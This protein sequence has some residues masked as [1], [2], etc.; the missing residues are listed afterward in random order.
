MAY[1]IP[2]DR[3]VIT[4]AQTGAITNKSL[5]PK[6]PEQPAEIAESAL[7][8]F[9]QG[10]AIVHIH[11]RDP[12]GQNTSELAI[13][14]EIHQRIRSQCE[15]DHPGQHRRRPQPDPGAAH[16][17]P[18]GP[19]GHGLSE[20]GQHDAGLGPLQGGALVQ[21]ARGDR[22]VPGADDPAGH[23]AGDGGLQPRHAP[24]GAPTHQ[25]GPGGQALLRQ[26]RAGHALPGGRAGRPGHL[27]VPGAG[28]APGQH[29]QLH[30]GGLGPDPPGH[31][32]P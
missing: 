5:N 8:C 4:V 19:A 13:F 23:Q 7:A 28:P 12:Q 22:L 26:H 24:G 18:P 14:Q 25:R 1:A 29:L 3:V 20:H 11:A 30:R 9:N 32:W 6:V 10:A 16:Q 17:L 27:P 2:A 21:P 15:P 31:P